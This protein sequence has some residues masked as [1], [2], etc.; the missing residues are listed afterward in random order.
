MRIVCTKILSIHV[1]EYKGG[2]SKFSKTPPLYFEGQGLR[3]AK[4]YII[5][6]SRKALSWQAVFPV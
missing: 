2:I 6:Y 5:F 4:E 1:R 3:P